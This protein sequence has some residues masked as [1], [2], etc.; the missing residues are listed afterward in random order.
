MA[1]SFRMFIAAMVF[2]LFQL[3]FINAAMKYY[4]QIDVIPIF[5]TSLLVFNIVEGMIL[6]DEVSLY[7]SS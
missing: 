2:N 3:W 4:D 1:M 5:M 7:S 6:L